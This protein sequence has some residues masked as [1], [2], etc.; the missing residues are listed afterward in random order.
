MRQNLRENK[1]L[2]IRSDFARRMIRDRELT[3][4]LYGRAEKMPDSIY[5]EQ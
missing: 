5:A 4:L 3:Q 2:T 1:R